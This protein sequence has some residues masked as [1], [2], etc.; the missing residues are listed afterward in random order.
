MRS[1]YY[2]QHIFERMINSLSDKETKESFSI[3]HNI[4]RSLRGNFE[5]LEEQLQYLV[6]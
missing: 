2:S 3:F 5:K 4:V 1:N 6:T